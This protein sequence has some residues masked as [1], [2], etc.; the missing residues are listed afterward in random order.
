MDK[1]D[2]NQEENVKT[3][4]KLSEE[5]IDIL[6]IEISE[7][8]NIVI[9][10]DRIKY[11]EK[12]ISDFD[13]FDE[14]KT[15]VEAIPEIVQNPDYVG[16]HPNGKSIEFIKKIDKNMLVAVRLTNKK[17]LNFRSSYPITDEKLQTYVLSGRM[18]KVK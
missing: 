3:I 18:K 17:S 5:I 7:E 15:H 16:V 13:S 8:K 12:H 1:L 10:K 4:G 11:I 9:W 14:W 6:E 2:I